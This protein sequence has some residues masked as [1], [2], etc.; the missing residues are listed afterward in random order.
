MGDLGSDLRRA[1]ERA[2]LSLEQLSARTKIRQGLLDALEQDDLGR[3]PSGLLT[4]GYL[5]AYALEVGLDPESVVHRY[6]SEFEPSSP[7]SA[8]SLNLTDDEIDRIA[9]RIQAGVGVIILAAFAAFLLYQ[10]RGEQPSD[11]AGT[12]NVAWI[13]AGVSSVASPSLP[14]DRTPPDASRLIV[15]IDPTAV[16]W[17]QATADGRRVLYSLIHPDEPR[18]IEAR[19]ELVLLVGDAGAFRYTI[20]GVH[21]RPLG[22]SRQVREVRIKRDNRAEFHAPAAIRARAELPAP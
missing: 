18:V 5:R 19:E 4:R 16:V 11:T 8:R 12:L 3:L 10:N 13:G 17:V 7:T 21:G 9:T 6:R 20:N 1:R 14:V 2:G 15:R 22:A